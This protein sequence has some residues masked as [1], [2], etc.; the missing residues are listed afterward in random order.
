M[1]NNR[2]WIINPLLILAVTYALIA[3]IR[4]TVLS[5]LDLQQPSNLYP[6]VLVIPQF[7][8]L[9]YTV[10]FIRTNS[11]NIFNFNNITIKK[12]ILIVSISVIINMIF[13]IIYAQTVITINIPNIAPPLIPK[14]I[15]G[16]HSFVIVNLLAIC[17]F[18]PIIEEFFFR[19]VILLQLSQKT[20]PYKSIS[21]GSIIFAIVHADIGLFVPVFF[22]SIVVSYV[23][24]KW[25]SIWPV[26]FI[27][28]I[29]NLIVTIVASS[30]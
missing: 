7:F 13:A 26:I 27:H 8:L 3:L 15:L 12:I 19:G 28:S 4:I 2:Y 16:Q 14:Y 10:N 29:Q 11:L 22:S 6:W 18:V 5:D 20:S 24:L 25:K 1:I 23:F 21:I 17:V 9:F 30:A